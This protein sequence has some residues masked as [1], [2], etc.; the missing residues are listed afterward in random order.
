[1]RSDASRSRNGIPARVSSTAQARPDK[2]PPT[3]TTS[4]ELIGLLSHPSETRLRPP[5]EDDAH[6]RQ[7]NSDAAFSRS[8]GG[9]TTPAERARAKESGRASPAGPLPHI[10]TAE[11]TAY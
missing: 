7:H 4:G 8:S 3:M 6:H 9:L 5:G 1:M 2:P 10:R 11:N